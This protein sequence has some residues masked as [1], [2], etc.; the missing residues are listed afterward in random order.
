MTTLL[1]IVCCWRFEGVTQ[2][3][4]HTPYHSYYGSMPRLLLLCDNNSIWVRHNAQKREREAVP[5]ELLLRTAITVFDP[6][7][8][9]TFSMLSY[10]LHKCNVRGLGAGIISYH[11]M[12]PCEPRLLTAVENPTHRSVS[13]NII[14]IHI[15]PAL[16]SFFNKPCSGGNFIV[17]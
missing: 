1:I 14:G 7:S 2:L 16:K 6:G 5:T 8:L 11:I 3:D 13:T 9:K 4:S 12:L 15:L 17:Q 10:Q